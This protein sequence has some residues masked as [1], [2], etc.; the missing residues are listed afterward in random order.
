MKRQFDEDRLA[1]LATPKPTSKPGSKDEKRDKSPNS[2]GD[3]KVRDITDRVSRGKAMDFMSYLD[4]DVPAIDNKLK[5]KLEKAQSEAE[6]GQQ[7]GK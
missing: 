5:K 2:K 6:S 1:K 7:S 3:E 4:R